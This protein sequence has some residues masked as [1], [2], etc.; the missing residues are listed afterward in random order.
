MKLS[1]FIVV[2]LVLAASCQ[3]EDIR[4][5]GTASSSPGLRISPIDNPGTP[6]GDSGVYR[7]IVD[8]NTDTDASTVG[9]KGK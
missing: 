7:G 1:R 4:P 3:K 2:L 9:K 8:P 6:T 5:N